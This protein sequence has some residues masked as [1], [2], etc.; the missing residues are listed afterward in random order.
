MAEPSLQ[1]LEAIRIE[2]LRQ[3]MKLFPRGG[4]V[5]DLGAGTG[6]QTKMLVA[7][8]FDAVGVDLGGTLY[9][10]ARV[11]PIV[12]Y[13]GRE[14]PFG[15]AT[16]DVVYSSN[17]LEHISHVR[18]FQTEI[19]RV[20]KPNGIAVHALPTCCWTLW[21]SIT[22]MLKW[23]KL[24]APHGHHAKNVMTEMLFYFS[25]AFWTRLFT[26]TGWIVSSHQSNGLLYTGD[27]ILD[28]RLSLK[29]RKTLSLF[30]GSSGRIFVLKNATVD[31][32]CP[33]KMRQFDA[34]E[35]CEKKEAKLASHEEKSS[36]VTV[37]PA[38]SSSPQ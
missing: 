27:S 16:F 17:T 25:R 31:T 14:L 26:E 22:H 1:H 37:E 24:P 38:L 36:Q 3:V 28:S 15:D 9:S 13:N 10:K 21:S 11:W 30:L 7:E 18:E 33:R 29:A 35:A 32:P 5:L 19:Q 34:W 6:C 12:D 23:W 4:K 2:E 8:G 20:L